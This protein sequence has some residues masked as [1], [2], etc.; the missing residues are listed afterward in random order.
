MLAAGV[1]DCFQKPADVDR[2]LARIQELIGD[3][4]LA[5]TA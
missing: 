4:P 3:E 1:D 5:A 2:L